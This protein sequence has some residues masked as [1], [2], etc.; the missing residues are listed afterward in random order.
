MSATQKIYVHGGILDTR[1]QNQGAIDLTQKLINKY[2]YPVFVLKKNKPDLFASSVII[3][4]DHNY[5]LITASH[6]FTRVLS[7]DNTFVIG[8]NGGKYLPIS[9]KFIY[10]NDTDDN[11]DIAYTQLSSQLVNDNNIQVLGRK[12]IFLGKTL[13]DSH[14]V[15]IHGYPNSR[16]KQYKAF[17]DSKTSFRAKPYAFATTVNQEFSKW[18]DFGKSKENH[19]C[20]YYGKTANT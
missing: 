6:V 15:L 4:V 18:A 20:V 13:V 3:E 2:T 19:T 14:I 8:V 16:N 5:Y 7:V 17:M 1:K 10:T 9:S 11:F 12:R